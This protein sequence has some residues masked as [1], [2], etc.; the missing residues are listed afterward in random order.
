MMQVGIV[1]PRYP[2]NIAGGGEIS[3][4]LLAEQLQ[5]LT[6][7]DRVVVLSFDGSQDSMRNGVEVRRLSNISPFLTEWQNLRAVPHLRNAIEEFDVIH[8]YNMELHPAVG[9]LTENRSVSSVATLNSYHYL[10][11]AA[12]N[13]SPG[14]LNRLYELLGYPT[15]GRLLRKYMRKFDEFI[16]L[17]TSVKDIYVEHGFSSS[18]VCIIPNM[19]DPSFSTPEGQS[20]DEFIVLYVGT[21]KKVKGVEYLIRAFSHLSEPYK[22]R[23]VGDGTQR[24]KLEN[25]V[26]DL[27]LEDVVTFVGYVDHQNVPEQYAQ[28]DLFVH[29]GVW[30]EPFGRTIIEAMQA[31]L[32]VVCTDIGGPADIVRDSNL[33]CPPR[34]SEALA[35][36]IETVRPRAS[37]IGSRNSEYVH[38]EYGPDAV[39]PQ[40][41]GLYHRVR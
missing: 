6:D 20:T 7:I 3:A 12:V 18:S 33:R 39:I 31:G 10:P 40:I 14:P 9:A 25:L 35:E 26:V 36:A 1:T 30:P 23:V 15:T 16:A 13:V 38:Q 27:Q 4:A 28:A 32:P 21:L 41:M 8:S 5:H 19:L 29:P 22:L 24:E 2:P 37:E 11:K 34:D 17:S